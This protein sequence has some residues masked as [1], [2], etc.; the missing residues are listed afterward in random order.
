METWLADDLSRVLR[1]SCWHYSWV[2]NQ[3]PVEETLR[4]ITKEMTLDMMIIDVRVADQPEA[5]RR[6]MQTIDSA[7]Y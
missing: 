3:S 6:M 4:M 1:S 2:R 7:K 5:F